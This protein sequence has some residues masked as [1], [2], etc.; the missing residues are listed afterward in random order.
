ML[1]GAKV[2]LDLDLGCPDDGGDLGKLRENDKFFVD[3]I[4][5]FRLYAIRSTSVCR[6]PNQKSLRPVLNTHDRNSEMNF[7]AHS[8]SRYPAC[9][10]ASTDR[11][12][13]EGGVVVNGWAK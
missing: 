9:P 12:R 7:D 1:A 11:A 13:H 6:R 5:R 2:L 3:R 4:H 8:Q 10:L